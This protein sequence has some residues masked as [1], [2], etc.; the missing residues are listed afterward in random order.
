[1]FTNRVS[2]ASELNRYYEEKLFDIVKSTGKKI[3]AW[4]ARYNIIDFDSY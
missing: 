4:Q 3:A 2:N 1:M